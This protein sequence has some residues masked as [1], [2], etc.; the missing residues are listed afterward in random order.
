MDSFASH[1]YHSA[2]N[3]RRK[4][5]MRPISI[6]IIF[7]MLVLAGCSFPGIHKDHV[8]QGNQLITERVERLEIG[9]TR[10]QVQFLSDH[11]S[12]LTHLI[13]TAGFIWS[14]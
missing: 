12:R 3:F 1:L 14:V 4:I 11:Q 9:M 10:D 5:L 13:Q 2:K 8:K 7:A 6:H